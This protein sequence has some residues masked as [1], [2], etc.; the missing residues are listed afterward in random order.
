MNPFRRLCVAVLIVLVAASTA[1]GQESRWT[2]DVA[3]AGLVEAWDL[4]DQREQLHGVVAG[5]T[6]RAWRGLAIRGEAV[7][8]L[9]G[10]R[11]A[12]A[13][14]TG[15]W[16]GVSAR[17]RGYV[18]PF[19]ELGAGRAFARHP[20]PPGGTRWNY[21]L[22]ASAGVEIPTSG[23]H[24]TLGLRW[25]HVSNGGTEGRSQNPDIQAL[26]GRFGLSWSF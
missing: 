3:A 10:Q 23:P 16:F 6:F 22:V 1:G 20:V 25:L 2:A 26:G 15:G 24:V 4:N 17:G 9:V 21:L 18:R 13:W 19:G 14:L 8:I 5:A 12:D 7:R 11:G